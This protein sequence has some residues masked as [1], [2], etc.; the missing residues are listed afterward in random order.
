LKIKQLFIHLRGGDLKIK[1]I[2]HQYQRRKRLKGKKKI[3]FINKKRKMGGN[4]NVNNLEIKY[5]KKKIVHP[6]KWRKRSANLEV[7]L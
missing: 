7:N 6:S 2:F 4:I 1:Q 5:S 3:L